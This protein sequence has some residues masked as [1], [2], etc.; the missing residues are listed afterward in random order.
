MANTIRTPPLDPEA[1][2]RYYEQYWGLPV[3]PVQPPVVQPDPPPVV[4]Q[5]DPPPVVAQPDPPPVEQPDPAAQKAADRAQFEQSCGVIKSHWGD[6]NADWFGNG[7]FD[8]NS[9]Y[10]ASRGADPELAKAA[11][12][13]ID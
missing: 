12:F 7:S 5:P 2:N 10:A 9:L 1:Y 3:D 11:Q 13:L 6:M 4:A 8:M